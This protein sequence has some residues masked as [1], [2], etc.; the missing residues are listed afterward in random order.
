MGGHHVVTTTI[1]STVEST[2]VMTV[3]CSRF[4]CQGRHQALLIRPK[5]PSPTLV[6]T[7]CGNG[8]KGNDGKGSGWQRQRWQGQ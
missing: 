1:K 3:D 6:T 2:V 8:G 5:L 7:A 4:R